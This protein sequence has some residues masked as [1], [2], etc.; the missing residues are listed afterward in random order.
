MKKKWL[1]LLMGV[2][3]L[4]ASGC[5][6]K[7]AVTA[8]GLLGNPYGVVVESGDFDITMKLTNAEGEQTTSGN[9]QFDKDGVHFKSSDK[10]YYLI[11]NNSYI[12]GYDYVADTGRW[13][14]KDEESLDTSVLSNL[15]IITNAA[16]ADWV[17]TGDSTF[18]K[19]G[20]FGT[21][22]KCLSGEA[23]L[24]V[25]LTFDKDTKRLL[26]AEYV[27]KEEQPGGVKAY[28]LTVVCKSV[29]NIKVQLPDDV[30]NNA[31]DENGGSSGLSSSGGGL[32]DELI[33]TIIVSQDD[34]TY[35]YLDEMGAEYTEYEGKLY[36]SMDDYG[37]AVEKKA[38][39]EGLTEFVEQ[40]RQER[41]SLAA[42]GDDIGDENVP[43]TTVADE[44]TTAADEESTTSNE[45]GG[46]SENEPTKSTEEPKPI[47]SDDFFGL[48]SQQEKYDALKDMY[49][50]F[51]SKAGSSFDIGEYMAAM[52]YSNKD[53][54]LMMCG[55]WSSLTDM[56]KVGIA[57]HV[58]LGTVSLNECVSAGADGDFITSA[59]AML[60]E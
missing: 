4:V 54:I 32:P 28:S 36:F 9:L 18:D 43:E 25:T 34:P 15:G 46:S 31:I 21:C 40:V 17:V 2:S 1:L 58:D 22:D 57:I 48:A 51:T 52:N 29:N 30:R 59:I 24:A 19:A 26:K 50:G 8:E 37:L 60:K 13:I 3:V 11:R 10:E 12:K 20:H 47:T 7:E 33:G 49:P 45:S 38:E 6:K 39:S 23:P 16:L 53:G 44:K 42:L 14:V 5:S 55:Y 27:L 41:E 35:K 56:D